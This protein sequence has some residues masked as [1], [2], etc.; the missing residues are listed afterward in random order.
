MAVT[1]SMLALVFTVSF[2]LTYSKSVGIPSGTLCLSMPSFN[3]RSSENIS[4]QFPSRT[5]CHP[6]PHVQIP[7]IHRPLIIEE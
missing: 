6:Y 7:S 5:N 3:S 4:D 2:C 1:A